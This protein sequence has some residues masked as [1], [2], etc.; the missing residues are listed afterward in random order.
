LSVTYIDALKEAFCTNL[1]HCKFK[2]DFNSWKECQEALSLTLKK[3]AKGK[4]MSVAPWSGCVIETNM[5][6]DTLQVVT[7][8]AKE[9]HGVFTQAS[10]NNGM[11]SAE[12]SQPFES[13]PENVRDTLAELACYIF[14]NFVRR[15]NE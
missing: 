5:S 3:W 9:I 7:G 4:G 14:D 8:L 1:S 10:I 11:L 2:A 15:K 12:D 6:E 13:V